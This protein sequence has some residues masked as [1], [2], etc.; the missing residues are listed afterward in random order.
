MAGLR[1]VNEPI[2]RAGLPPVPEDQI[3]AIINRDAL[4]RL[5]LG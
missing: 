1:S 4:D 5:G 2:A 3:E